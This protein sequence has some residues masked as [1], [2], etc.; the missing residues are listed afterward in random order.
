MNNPKLTPERLLRKAIVYIRQSKPSQLVHNQESTRLQH[1]L[2]DRARSLGFRRIIVIDDDL[3]RTGSG[4]VDRP[5]FQRLAA[6]VCSGEVSAVFCVEASRLARNGRDWHHLIELCGMVGAVVVDLDGVYDPT[7][8][9]DRLLLGMK[10]TISEFEVNLFR[11]RSTEAILQKARRGELQ[12]QIPVGFCWAPSGKLEKDPDQR[13]QQAIQLVFRKMTELGTVRQVLRWFREQNLFLPAFPHDLGERKMIWKLPGYASLHS[14]LTNPIYAGAYVYGKTETQTKIVE[15]RARKSAG[16][17]K[18]Q[19]G[20]KVLIKEHHPGYL[21]WEEY[22]RNQS[23]IAANAHIHSGTEP[24]AGRG[25]GALLSGLLRCRR[26]GRMIHVFYPG[27]VVRYVCNAGRAQYGESTCISF[28]G[29]RVDAAVSDEV[30]R[31]VSGNAL[32]AAS[33]AAEQVQQK[34]QDLRKAI[35]L[36]LEQA[37]YESRLAARRYESVDPEQRLVVAE[38]EARWNTA[39][40]KTKELENRLQ[41]FDD[42]SQSS[43][44][45]NKEVLLSLA[46]DLPTIWNSPSTNMRLKQRIVRILIREI[47]ADVE[48]KNR[49][50][51][52]VIH[53]TGGC[54]SELRVKKSETGRSRRCT[55]PETIEVL[56][57]MAGKFSDQQIATTLNRLRLRTGVGNAWN[58][59]RVRSAR[60]YYQLPAFAQNDQPREVTLQVAARRLNVSQSIVRRMIEEKIL[61]ANQVVVCAPWQIPVEALD[62]EV[63]HELA[64]NIKNG[65][66]VPQSQGVDGQQ[67]MFS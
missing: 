6:E 45:P 51:V 31:V 23:M 11:Q 8:T 54:H 44:I 59:M 46:Q 17:R 10:G 27:T 32:H 36:E 58:V 1:S 5:G 57:Q 28:G 21:S 64:T 30:L 60:S 16:H 67:S 14:M 15:G 56:R 62:S 38:L 66:R 4:L 37:R 9:N 18:P 19:S 34:R 40:Q 53:W 26:C 24:K 41:K 20:W 52:L 2:A 13:V 47:I 48:A 3:G 22:E 63:I 35:E 29:L 55:D 7:L 25:G 61:P 33:D 43:P 39:L 42:E 49:E 50:V 12:I 65:A